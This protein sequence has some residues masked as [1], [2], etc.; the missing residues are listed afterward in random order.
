MAFKRK[1]PTPPVS[2]PVLYDFPIEEDL[3]LHGMAVDEA[4][5]A[6]AHL[7]D[8]YKGRPGAIVRIIHGHSNSAPDSIRKSLYRNF[9]TVW[10][11]RVTRYR[12]DIHN[13][14]A[15]LVELVG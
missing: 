7:L 8:R 15:T 3:D 2:V 1:S 4:L 5:A 12:M 13:P 10:K 14:G 6:A 11:H 9:K